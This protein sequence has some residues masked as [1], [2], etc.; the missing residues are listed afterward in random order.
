MIA[1]RKVEGEN[2]RNPRNY[3]NCLFVALSYYGMPN[4]HT[5]ENLSKR[6]LSRCFVTKIAALCCVCTKKKEWSPVALS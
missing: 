6:C 3:S 2:E 5:V 4:L 1:G